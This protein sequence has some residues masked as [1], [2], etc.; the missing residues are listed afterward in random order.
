[1]IPTQNL[2]EW[3]TA[4][5]QTLTVSDDYMTCVGADLVLTQNVNELSRRADAGDAAAAEWLQRLPFEDK[6]NGNSR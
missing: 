2:I 5:E 1:M 4:A 6:S 3:A